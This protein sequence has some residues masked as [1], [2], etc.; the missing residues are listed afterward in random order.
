MALVSNVALQVLAVN[1][2]SGV[3]EISKEIQNYQN[4]F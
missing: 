2:D 1:S 3:I 4:Y